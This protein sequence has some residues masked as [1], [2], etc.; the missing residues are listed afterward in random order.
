MQRALG[1]GEVVRSLVALDVVDV[2]V[3][4]GADFP[5]GTGVAASP[6]GTTDDTTDA[7]TETTDDR[8]CGCDRTGEQDTKEGAI[9]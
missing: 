1:V 5:T 2:T 6:T 4:I 7:T 3:V 9:A 8:S